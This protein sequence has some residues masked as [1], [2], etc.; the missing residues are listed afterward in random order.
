[1]PKPKIKQI[2]NLAFKNPKQNDIQKQNK[3]N[4]DT[5]TKKY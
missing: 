4:K 1:M 3:T 2:K 5:K